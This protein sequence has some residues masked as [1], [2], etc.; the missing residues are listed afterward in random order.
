LGPPFQG[1]GDGRRSSFC[2]EDDGRG[3]SEFR[4]P[5]S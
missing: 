1:Q 2:P 3:E 4:G 5:Y